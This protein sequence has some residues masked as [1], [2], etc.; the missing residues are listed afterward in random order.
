[1]PGAS[2]VKLTGPYVP[3]PLTVTVCGFVPVPV[4]AVE[5]SLLSSVKRMSPPAAAPAG[6]LMIG[7]PGCVEVPVRVARSWTA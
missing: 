7:L 3:S 1:M 5:Q 6:P 2:G 4:A